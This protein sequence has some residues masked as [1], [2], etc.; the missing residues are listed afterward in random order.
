MLKSTKK[1]GWNIKVG[2]KRGNLFDD[3][4]GHTKFDIWTYNLHP[5]SKQSNIVCLQNIFYVVSFHFYCLFIHTFVCGWNLTKRMGSRYSSKVVVS[6]KKPK[7]SNIYRLMLI[8]SSLVE[9]GCS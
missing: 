7:I 2:T 9:Q 5:T 3:N 8:S 1:N 6:L 4:F